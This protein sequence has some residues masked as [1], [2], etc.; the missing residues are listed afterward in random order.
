MQHSQFISLKPWLLQTMFFS[1]LGEVE[2]LEEAV[3]GEIVF[4]LSDK[5]VAKCFL[6]KSYFLLWKR[7]WTYFTMIALS[8]C[9]NSDH[10]YCYSTFSFISLVLSYKLNIIINI[11]SK[12]LLIFN[13]LFIIFFIY[14]SFMLLRTLFL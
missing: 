8:P 3:V 13:F 4:S 6:L 9:C 10:L 11:Y 14:L 12:D 1:L 5:D 7:L 2:R